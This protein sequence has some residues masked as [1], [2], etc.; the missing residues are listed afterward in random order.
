MTHKLQLTLPRLPLMLP[1]LLLMLL[2]GLCLG[3]KQMQTQPSPQLML[4][5]QMRTLHYSR[6][7]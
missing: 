2:Q 3:S 4:L 5:K 1:R 7:D 6:L